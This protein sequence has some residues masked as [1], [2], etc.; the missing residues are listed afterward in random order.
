MVTALSLV[1]GASGYVGTHLVERLL[2]Q[3]LPVRAAAR[4]LKVLQAREWIGAELVQADA[5]APASLPAALAG[6]DVAYYL[7]HS[8]AAGRHFG[9]L[10]LQAARHFAQAA[11]AAGV[12]RIVY[13]GGLVPPGADSEHLVSRQATGEV[14][15]E[16]PVPVTELRAGIIVG[17]GSA[18]YEVIR[19]LVN[20]LPLMVTP[21]WVNSRSSPLALGNLLTYLVELPRH[22]AA[23]GQIYDAGGPEYLSYETMMRRFGALVGRRPRIVPVPLLTPWLSALW[24]ALITT[25]PASIARALIGGLKHDIPAHDAAL[26]ALVPQNL[27]GFDDAVRAALQAERDHAVAARWTEGRLMFR[28]NRLDHAFYAKRAGG[29]ALSSASPEAL[30]QVVCGIGG[31]DRY[32]TLNFLW[33]LRELVDWLFGGPGFSRGR[34]DPAQLRLGDTIDYWTVI[35][36]QAPHRLTLHF[37]MKCPGS[38]V[39]EYEIESLA[40]G[41]NRLTV[42]A[43][44]HPRGVWGLLYWYALVPAHLFLFRR[45]TRVMA[46]R[47]EQL[48][49]AVLT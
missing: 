42:T 49:T 9:Q 7:V 24:L 22:E 3:G 6:V 15:R 20:H 10:D 44:W 35:G 39:L 14:L 34:R 46:R 23:A 26:R 33:W 36:L 12:R 16:G 11:A 17:A 5:L 45:F 41:R 40:P 8:M 25:V 31:P 1:F 32:Y 2:Q 21:R 48:D 13:L 4:N 18:A 47:A 29:S 19:D 37:G 30:W 28:G 38:G 27:L 43:Y